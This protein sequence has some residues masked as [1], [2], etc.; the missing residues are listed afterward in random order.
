MNAFKMKL[1]LILLG[2]L[3]FT[4]GSAET[5]SCA[6][7]HAAN[8]AI[9]GFNDVHLTSVTV[10]QC[11]EAC[12]ANTRCKSFDYYKRHN[13]CD[14]SFSS[15]SAVGGLKTDY[16]GNP[17][18]HYALVTL[19]VKTIGYWLP[20]PE[21]RLDFQEVKEIVMEFSGSSTEEDSRKELESFSQDLKEKHS[22]EVAFEIGGAI[23][24]IEAKL[25]AKYAYEN[26]RSRNE[27]FETEL[28]KL[29]SRTYSQKTIIK[30][31]ITVPA[32]KK[33]ESVFQNVWVWKT[34]AI[35]EDLSHAG[36]FL[37]F[38][39]PTTGCGYDVPPNCLPGFCLDDHC[40]DCTRK[41]ME[42][43]PDFVKPQCQIGEDCE[44]VAIPTKDC[45]SRLEIQELDACTLDMKH[46]ELCEAD[47]PLPDRINDPDAHDSF[48]VNNCP[49]N[50]DVFRYI[51]PTVKDRDECDFRKTFAATGCPNEKISQGTLDFW[52]R[53]KFDAVLVDM[54]RY[55]HVV[56]DGVATEAQKQE[57]CGDSIDC[58][59][60]LKCVEQ[61]TFT[62]CH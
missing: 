45:P 26:E 21:V 12:C 16:V 55:C 56:K 7:E 14:L 4:I 32:R 59:A 46:G 28:S 27:K 40:W 37:D 31:K 25:S 33:H 18:D 17:F 47:S 57:C 30:R 34:E 58:Q 5:R 20:R 51:C 29:A 43:N 42:I 9:S 19:G 49:N 50:M 39:L 11:K 8:A 24:I 61:T 13:A 52:E 2:C 54:L 44:W 15:A 23:K 38:A 62:L 36:H 3:C 60:G 22:A 35:R 41:D 10:D 48:D 53:Q 6:W 1:L